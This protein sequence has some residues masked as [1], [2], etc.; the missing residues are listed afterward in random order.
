MRTTFNQNFN[1]SKIMELQNSINNKAN[2]I[3]NNRVNLTPAENPLKFSEEIKLNERLS[4][5]E[6]YLK[7]NNDISNKLSYEEVILKK[8]SQSFSKLKE[9]SIKLSSPLNNE[10]EINNYTKEINEMQKEL[11]SLSNIKDQDDNY[12]FSGSKTIKPFDNESGNYEYKGDQYNKEYQI[13]DNLYVKGNNNGFELFE[14][15]LIQKEDSTEVKENIFNVLETYK[16][17]LNNPTI[18]VSGTVNNFIEN[19]DRNINH[20]N[21]KLLELGGKLNLLESNENSNKDF[22]LYH[23]ERLI[24]ITG[25]DLYKT[26]SEIEKEKVLLDVIY[27]TNEKI[28]KLSLFNYI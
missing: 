23:Q 10:T 28:S 13:S 22:E 27:K 18:N 14:N 5:I 1:I 7:N 15:V 2:Q 25:V 6:S 26:I 17:D 3:A 9:L 11:F 8:V 19:I 12:L 21:D 20:I 16:L 24:D 4:K